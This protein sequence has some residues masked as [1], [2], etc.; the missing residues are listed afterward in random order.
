MD[1]YGVINSK[2]ISEHC[3]KINHQFSPLE[4]AYL[5]YLNDTMLMEEKHTAYQDI[6]SNQ[7][8]M[9]IKKR[10]R[11]P[12]FASLHSFLKQYMDIEKRYLDLF[13]AD[14]LACVYSF[15]ILY[16]D[17]SEYSTDERIFRSWND[18]CNAIKLECEEYDDLAIIDIRIKKQWINEDGDKYPKLMRASFDKNIVPMNIWD[19]RF[20]F[21]EED[22]EVWNAF[23]RM[24]FNIPVPFKEGD[25][26]VERKGRGIQTSSTTNPVV[27]N[28]IAAWHKRIVERHKES[29][30]SSDYN[31]GVYG[32]YDDGTF[33]NFEGPYSYLDLE[34]YDGEF[35]GKDKFLVSVSNFLKGDNDL[36][37]LIRSYDVLKNEHRAN[38]LRKYIGCPTEKIMMNAG[39]D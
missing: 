23:D 4:M 37:L 38:E 24:W 29:G 8:D 32:V 3:R 27:L 5:V 12:A 34:Y 31:T 35:V 2:A 10:H 25:I 26:V 39:L 7:P 1:I 14:E 13:Y 21:S 30:D 36:E 18:C 15:E 17:D 19:E 20:V 11:T 16:E 22:W 9:E 33:Y 6:I 28:Y